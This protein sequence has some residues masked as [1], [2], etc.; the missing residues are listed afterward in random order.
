M[1]RHEGVG[2]INKYIYICVDNGAFIAEDETKYNP[3]KG[4]YSKILYILY[5]L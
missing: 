4:N 2:D 1:T 5:D 3:E